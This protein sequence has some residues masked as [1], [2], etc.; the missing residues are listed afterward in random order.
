[1]NSDEEEQLLDQLIQ[2]ELAEFDT[3][4]EPQRLEQMTLEEL[5][6]GSLKA[7]RT[8]EDTL[9]PLEK[10]NVIPFPSRGKLLRDQMN[11]PKEQQRYN[12]SIS[13]NCSQVIPFCSYVI[14][15][16]YSRCNGHQS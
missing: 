16:E 8:V 3:P 5:F 15:K 10:S 1:M 6:S 14:Y 13:S 2:A 4:W 7:K 12:L 9:G 11:K